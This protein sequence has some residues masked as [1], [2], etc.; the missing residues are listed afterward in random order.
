ML[1]F[2]KNAAL[3]YKL[4]THNL[5]VVCT[6]SVTAWTTGLFWPVLVLCCQRA[7][8]W[9]AELLYERLVGGYLDMFNRK[10]ADPCCCSSKARTEHCRAGHIV[11]DR[12]PRGILGAGRV[13]SELAE[14]GL[15]RCLTSSARQ[16][17]D[18][19]N[20]PAPTQGAIIS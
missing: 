11:T 3:W 9:T 12:L 7:I 8:I 16:C 15:H 17:M 13:H 4:Y 14:G 18:I 2:V 10:V 6:S 5:Y 19:P 1:R 20:T